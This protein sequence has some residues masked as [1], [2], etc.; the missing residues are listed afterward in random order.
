MITYHCVLTLEVLR[1][2]GGGFPDGAGGSVFLFVFSLAHSLNGI[3]N[4]FNG[5]LKLLEER[6][7]HNN[8]NQT[9]HPIPDER[10]AS[11]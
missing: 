4:N 6:G 7:T 3:Y 2:G 9:E 1:G 5:K 10:R 11:T 8:G